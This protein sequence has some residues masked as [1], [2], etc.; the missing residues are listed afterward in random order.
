MLYKSLGV[1]IMQILE[2]CTQRCWLFKS[3]GSPGNLYF[4]QTALGNSDVGG[5][6]TIPGEGSFVALREIITVQPRPACLPLLAQLLLNILQQRSSWDGCRAAW[7]SYILNYVIFSST[8]FTYLLKTSCNE[9]I[10]KN[11]SGNSL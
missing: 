3:G 4:Q 11:I 8:P 6:G 10:C 2:S 1:H 9:W 7:H 5:S